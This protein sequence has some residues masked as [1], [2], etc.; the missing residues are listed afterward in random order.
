MET[1]EFTIGNFVEDLSGIVGKVIGIKT[2]CIRVEFDKDVWRDLKPEQLKLA[3]K[4]SAEM[5]YD[6]Y[7]N[8][9]IEFMQKNEVYTTKEI[10][11]LLMR[12]FAQ[13]L[14]DK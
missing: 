11:I 2:G 5:L 3:T 9:P 6:E 10:T 13:M 1:N 7:A 4:K 12:K 14:N 8:N